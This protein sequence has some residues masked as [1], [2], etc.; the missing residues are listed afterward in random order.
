MKLSL[1]E[2]LILTSSCSGF[3]VPSLQA[4]SKAAS[5]GGSSSFG[6]LFAVLEEQAVSAGRTHKAPVFDEVCET[7]GV[8][9]KRFMTEVAMLNPELQEL[10]A[11]F[12]AIDTSCKAIANVVKRSQL[13]SSSV[14]GYQGAVNVQ[15]E[16]QKVH[17]YSVHFNYLLETIKY[18][19]TSSL[20]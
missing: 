11:L 20:Q 12:G 9:L 14:L 4:S 2:L 3:V 17:L 19:P 7:T 10:T 16:D 5:H 1:V 6:R 8:T 18:L 15:G 13:P